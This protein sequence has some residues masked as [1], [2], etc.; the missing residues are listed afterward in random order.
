MNAQYVTLLGLILAM[1]LGPGCQESEPEV[2]DEATMQAVLT[3]L[4]LADAWVEQ[5]G[6]NLLAR[7]VKREGV[8]DEVLARYDLDRKTFYRSYLYYL[9]HAVQLDSIYARLVKDLEAME[10]STQRER[11][12]RRNEVSG[13]ANP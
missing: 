1:L 4:H 13:G 5:N 9:D 6:G 10:M 7:G 12:Q 8:F 3:D 11:M 2:L